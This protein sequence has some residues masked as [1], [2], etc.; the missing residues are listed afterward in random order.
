MSRLRTSALDHP[1]RTGTPP[2][3]KHLSPDSCLGPLR[4]LPSPAR[5]S[6]C[7]RGEKGITP[8]GVNENACLSLGAIYD[9][10]GANCRNRQCDFDRFAA[11]PVNQLR[12]K[13]K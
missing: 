11:R 7:L 9:A 2:G 13:L 4:Q 12:M 8:P 3:P 6:F 10:D 5:T 1:R